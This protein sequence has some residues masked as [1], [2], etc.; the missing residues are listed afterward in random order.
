M[1]NLQQLEPALHLEQWV[2]K[3]SM[4][5]AFRI[6]WLATLATYVGTSIRKK[7]HL[8]VSLRG[9]VSSAISP[10]ALRGIEKLMP[11][12]SGCFSAGVIVRWTKCR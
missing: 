12:F 2:R 7:A 1:S 3:S 9:K 4:L 6:R 10:A 5:C 8:A 11:S